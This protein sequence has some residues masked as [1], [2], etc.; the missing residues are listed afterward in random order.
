MMLTGHWS[1]LISLKNPPSEAFNMYQ[2][3]ISSST[4]LNRHSE[5]KCFFIL[6]QLKFNSRFPPLWVVLA[7]PGG[8]ILYI[9]SRQ[10]VPADEPNCQHHW[11]WVKNDGLKLASPHLTAK[12]YKEPGILLT[13]HTGQEAQ[14]KIQMGRC[15]KLIDRLRK[16]KHLFFFLVWFPG[17]QST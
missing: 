2:S 4:P 8:P 9:A 11:E 7:A 17:L 14:I 12:I 15:P 3:R 10:K 6:A 16:K 1:L 5:A 13:C